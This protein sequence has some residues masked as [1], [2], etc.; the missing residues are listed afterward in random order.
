MEESRLKSA[1]DISRL[2]PLFLNQFIHLSALVRV[3][4]GAGRE[5][6]AVERHP[7]VGKAEQDGTYLHSIPAPDT[8]IIGK[9]LISENCPVCPIAPG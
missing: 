4:H 1:V 3:T 8:P 2:I 7:F 9:K 5:E 6:I